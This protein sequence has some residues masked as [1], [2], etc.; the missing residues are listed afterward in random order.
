M[1]RV[2]GGGGSVRTRAVDVLREVLERGARAAPLVGE[3]GTGLGEADRG[4]LRELV[5]GVLRWKDAL[6]A[7]IAGVS[8]VPLPR[9]APNLREI[10]EVALYQLRHLDRIPDYAAVSEAVSHAKASGGEGAARLVNGV[11]RG[12][13]LLPPPPVPGAVGAGLA[14]ARGRPQGP[15]LQHAEELARTLATYYSHPRFLVERWLDRFGEDRTRRI[16]EAD[17]RPPGL[18][19]MANPRRTDRESLSAALL[20]EGI[21][22]ETSALAPLALTVVS[23]NPI[24]SPLFEAGHFFVQDVGS[25]ALPLL[26]P[27]GETLLDLA[28][29]PGGKSFSAI[30]HGRCR[31]SV[32]LDLALVRLRL[33]EENRRRL[34]IPEARPVAADIAR[35]PFAP[36]RFERVLLDA[37]CS[38]TGTLRKNPESRYRVTPEAVERLARA[39]ESFL[40]AAAGLLAPGGY[41]LYSTCSLEEEEN[42]RVVAR[43]LEREPELS[44]APIE[45]TDGLAPFVDGARLRLF[46]DEH[47]DGFTAHLLRR[48]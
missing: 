38:G 43:V 5:L 44:P 32:A 15:P 2:S 13:L 4:L 17:N 30:A 20:A 10:L 33:L 47:T 21:R 8:R 46:P 22:T 41:L 9:L 25:Q 26:L 23:G 1:T 45:G 14:P 19:L 6:D 37:P 16:L 34:G 36:G 3:R 29:A 12:I 27:A 24:R 11:L 42:E 40:A 7:E 35:L 28:A 31:Q 48:R 18:D 39:Q